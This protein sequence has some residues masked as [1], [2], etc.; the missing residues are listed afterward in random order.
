MVE[1]EILEAFSLI[2]KTNLLS[3][4]RKTLNQFDNSPNS[5][6][7]FTSILLV[8]SDSP[9]AISIDVKTSSLTGLVISLLI[10][11]LI[12]ILIEI[13]FIPGTT[14]FGIIGFICF[15][16]SNYY[17]Y[18]EFGNQVGLIVS[19]I[20]G[21]SLV[22]AVIYVLKSKT[23]EKLSLKKTNTAQFN[24]G[25]TK[26]LKIGDEGVTASSLKPY[27]KGIFNGKVYEIKTNGN[28]IKEQKKIKIIDILHNKIIVKNL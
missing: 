6:L 21:S 24:K 9:R 27:G 14:I 19:I 1:C 3:L 13:I 25:K 15:L 10:I 7:D 18:T 2:P 12:L 11:G 4:S 5:S 17:S 20:S 22:L 28:Y 23:W 26:L 8:K 16:L